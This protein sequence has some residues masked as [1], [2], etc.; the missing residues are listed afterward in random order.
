LGSGRISGILEA[1]MIYTIKFP[2][3]AGKK[4]EI[5]RYP[6]GEAQVRIKPEEIQAITRADEVHVWARIKDG[7]V[8]PLALLTEALHALVPPV[9]RLFLPYL[10]YGR[11]DRRFVPG[12]CFGLKVF[13]D[14]VNRM[15]YD[16]VVT[17]DAHSEQAEI[18]INNLLN[19]SPKVLISLV[20]TELEAAETKRVGI[21]L[22]DSGASRYGIQT[23]L[24]A[25][26]IRD[27]KTGV[28]SGFSVPPREA[29]QGLD[30]VLIVDDVCDGGGT[31]L[32]IADAMKDYGLELN[33]FV[34][35]GI[36]SK[37]LTDLFKRFS[38][39]YTT[40]SF[41]DQYFSRI[42]AA[43]EERSRLITISAGGILLDAVLYKRD[44]WKNA[45]H[46]L[47]QQAKKNLTST[48]S[49]IQSLRGENDEDS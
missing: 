44:L 9:T 43:P 7:E 31:F 33:L 39:I 22:P 26:K 3:D 1:T 6:G 47:E 38:K 11:A 17:L 25:E 40:D 46:G 15:E 41:R 34:S 8:M 20:Q 35:H 2:E 27:A 42:L 37:R 32:G 19:V 18:E 30:S 23:N 16:Q 4:F 36:F 29:F 14:A 12:D 5:F 21:L 10:P 13:A 45:K 24:H 49:M 48:M 28:L